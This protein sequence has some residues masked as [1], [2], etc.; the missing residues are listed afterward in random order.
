MRKSSVDPEAGRSRVCTDTRGREGMAEL[1]R[2][3][4][5]VQI[6]NVYSLQHGRVQRLLCMRQGQLARMEPRD[7]S[8]RRGAVS[9]EA[10]IKR[11]FHFNPSS[12]TH[13][14]CSC[15]NKTHAICCP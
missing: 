15:K 14:Y 7:E 12:T 4:V 5:S 1:Q 3:V 8:G 10:K 13:T 11:E 9:K 6:E 2:A